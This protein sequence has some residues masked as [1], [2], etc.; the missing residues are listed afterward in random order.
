LPGG[1]LRKYRDGAYLREDWLPT[2][3][4]GEEIELGFGIDQSVIV[5][6]VDE[7]GPTAET[8]LMGRNT[9]VRHD[10]RFT[11]LNRHNT[12]FTVEVV[13]YRPVSED[14]DITLRV[15][16]DAT[17]ADEEGFADTPGVLV[18]RRELA[19]EES[20]EVRNAYTITHPTS[21]ILVSR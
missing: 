3:I 13:D 14:D 20:L 7:S 17:P 16:P 18:W 1:A 19:P 21:E 15:S 2:L 4:P 5:S 8:G 11:A 10:H 9:E 12:P 6:W